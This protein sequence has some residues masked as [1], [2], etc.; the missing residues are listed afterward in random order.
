MDTFACLRGYR[1]SAIAVVSGIV[2]LASFSPRQPRVCAAENSASFAERIIRWS[3]TN[4][5]LCAF[6][7]SDESGVLEV[8]QKTEMLVTVRVANQQAAERLRAMADKQGFGI[9]RLVVEQ[10]NLNVLPFVDHLV[11]AVIIPTADQKALESLAA[12]EVVRCLRPHGLAIV[13]NPNA[14][15]TSIPQLE[16]WAKRGGATAI[17]PID[18]MAG[19]WIRMS[20]PALAGA[21]EWT[22]WENGPDN[23]PVSQDQVI[24][25]PYMT[26]FLAEPYYIGMPAITTIAG[27]RT[28]LAIGHIAH[29][30][31]E[32]DMLN[33]VIARNGYN[34]AL[35]W[36][37]PLPE[38]YL[39]HRSAF[40]ATPDTFYMID[41]D[42]CL[43][44][45]PRN[46]KEK[47]RLT[48]PGLF[49]EWK[50]MSL[51]DGVLYALAGRPEPGTETT[52]GDR[53]YGGWSWADLSKGYYGKRIPFGFGD[54]LAAFDV[55]EQQLL[56]SHTE[57]SLI[58]SRGMSMEGEQVYL[59]C[60]DKHLRALDRMTG[61]VK[62]T[63]ADSRTLDLIERPGQGLTSTPG[64][65]TASISVATPKAL[66]IQGQTRMNV[67]GVSPEDGQLL[68]SK[69]KITNNPNAI[70]L[71]DQLI[72]GVGPG[73]SHVRIDPESGDVQEDL[74]FRKTACTRLTASSDSLFCRGE[75]TLRFDR[76][77]GRLLIDGGARPGCNDGAIPANGLLYIGPWQCDCNLSL[78]GQVTKC[79]AGDFRFDHVARKEDRLE[80][81]EKPTPQSDA[82]ETIE[83]WPTLRGD[84]QRS[85]SSP[86]AV[87]STAEPKW[88]F[89]P[90]R[91]N[92]PTAP[93]SAG[94]LVFVGG[95]DGKVRALEVDGGAVR[96]EFA[97]PAPIKQ[98][99]T[100][101]MGRILFGGGDGFAYCLDATTGRQLWRFR[102]APVE[103]H[104]M[105]YGQLGST[106]PV[107]S[108]VLVRDGVAYFAAGIIDHDGT[109]VYAL[110]AETGHLQWQNNSSGHLSQD[111]RKGVSVQGNLS[112]LGNRLLLAGGN[113]VSPAPFDTETGKCLAEGFDQ[114]RPKA[115][116]GRFV[117]V[118]HD[119]WVI[120]GGRVLYSSPENVSTKGYF[121]ATTKAGNFRVN[122]GGVPPAW[123][124]EILAMVNFKHGSLTCC[125]AQV[126]ADRMEEGLQAK[127]N[128]RNRNWLNSLAEAVQ[129]DGSIRWQTDLGQSNKFEAIALAVCPNAIVCVISQQARFRAQPQWFVVALDQTD[130]KPIWRRE[131]SRQPIMDGLLVSRH[132]HVVVSLVGGDV[133]CLGEQDRSDG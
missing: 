109:Y 66:V 53:T 117:G 101:W 65:R 63:N 35:L 111:L 110:D 115:N 99:P 122:N 44:L 102:A 11:D 75:G 13:G 25:A 43:L 55:K 21:G 69:Q 26:Q 8:T 130:G 128:D 77:S 121:S 129:T 71:D 112:I 123:N 24:K 125:D 79:S 30:R 95:S 105:V 34:G 83:D 126:V 48:I 132:G 38:G 124:D 52:K 27:G 31:R 87:I 12:T 93:T 72:L 118:L 64:F 133:V 80:I 29:H 88:Q 60:P 17:E 6:V 5:G 68:W 103:R 74:K 96:W 100:F 94:D 127:G 3:G 39:V 98:P 7:G 49:G 58:D 120:N 91:A 114:G 1:W 70:Y 73:G 78:I 116:N 50:W 20:K 107:H 54:T 28:F 57:G 40:I 42:G 51:I 76:S 59:Y 36:E 86:V 113:Q 14:D 131:I 16:D 33:K 19:T 106:W 104:I 81:S 92:T 97:I 47:G 23:N 2:I 41:D 90:E 37:R 89:R 9:D 10:G 108:G 46:G 45:D 56:W 15:A 67:I 61:E 18:D 85:A 82:S 22:H 4:R 32:W 84:N 119:R 62:W